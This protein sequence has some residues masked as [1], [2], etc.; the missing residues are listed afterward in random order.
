ME[1][2]AWGCAVVGLVLGCGGALVPGF[3]GCAVALLGVVA[4]AGLTGFEIVTPPA[5]VVAALVTAAGAIGQLS[6]PVVSSRAFGGSAG[7]ATGAAIGAAFCSLIPLPGVAWG[8]A[9]VGALTLGLL[10]SRREVVGWLRGVLGTAGGCLVSI[11]IDLLAV[12]GVAA[13]LGV[14]DFLATQG[15]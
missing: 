3:P 8:G 15:M 4:F 6:G 9:L 14:S 2:L 11:G 10:A 1:I 7:A 13:V 12:L 5:L